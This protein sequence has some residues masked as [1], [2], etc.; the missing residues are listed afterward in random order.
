MSS[1]IDISSYLHRDESAIYSAELNTSAGSYSHLI[2]LDGE[3]WKAMLP[4]TE[5]SLEFNPEDREYFH[6]TP[7]DGLFYIVRTMVL[8]GANI[9]PV[10]D[11]DR[12][13]LGYY[14]LEEMLELWSDTPLFGDADTCLWIEKETRD[15]S[16]SEIT[17]ILESENAIIN[18]IL[19][20]HRDGEKTVCILRFSGENINE[21]IQSL[22]RYEYRIL[23]DNADDVL[24]DQME[25]RSGYLKKY[26]E[27]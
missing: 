1:M 11:E 4:A 26:L 21:I 5:G 27:F 3:L 17:Q 7:K 2:E 8:H 19:T 16:F 15:F 24:L 25:E 20:H 10:T 18:G 12:R 9:V 23:N 22:R 14:L 6:V 13:Y